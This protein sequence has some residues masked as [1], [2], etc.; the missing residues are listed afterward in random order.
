MLTRSE[1]RQLD[2]QGWLALRGLMP[3]ELLARLR[4]RIDEL[5]AAEGE[6]A[7][8]EFKQEPGARRLANLVNKGEVF[9]RVIAMPR[10]L[11]CVGGVL[12]PQFKLSSLNARSASPH[13]TCRQPLHA[14]AGA[15]ADDR[16]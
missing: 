1:C 10:V 8:S 4:R 13:S 5:F 14:D 7:G 2:E 11:E 9:H 3:P 6:R 15:V 12:G 16:G